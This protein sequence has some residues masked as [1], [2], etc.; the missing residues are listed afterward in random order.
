MPIQFSTPR[1][2]LRQWRISDF[3]PFAALNADPAVMACFP[4]TL[5]ADESH[6]M[7][8]HIQRLIAQR[9]WGLWAVEVPGEASFIGFVGLHEPAL[10][11]PCSPCIEIG[12]RLA[13]AYWGR[14]YATEAASG[15]LLVGFEL[16]DM[17]EIV[18]FTNEHNR[19]SRAVMERLGMH[20]GGE[21]FLH[22]DMPANS[23][24]AP[25]V[26]YRLTQAQWRADPRGRRVDAAPL[27]T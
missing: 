12:W 7:A 17:T 3:E 6:A 2:R 14:G 24:L 11:L 26:L 21:H 20:H 16:L 15:A 18:S 4:E 25:H 13:R 19:R 23:A 22:P 1:L 5:T 10:T 8:R 9:G 27:S